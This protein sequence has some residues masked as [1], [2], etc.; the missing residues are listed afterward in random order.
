MVIQSVPSTVDGGIKFIQ[1]GLIGHLSIMIVYTC[2]SSELAHAAQRS[3]SHYK[4]D[5]A[6]L[7]TSD[8]SK[9]F[10]IG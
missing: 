8:G 6:S 7:R 9:T 10:A 1:V 5:P 2:L 3:K 4:S